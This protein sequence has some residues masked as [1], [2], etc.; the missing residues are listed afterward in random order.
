[1]NTIYSENHWP[2]FH[3]GSTIKNYVA[4]WWGLAKCQQHYISSCDKI[5]NER[6]VPKAF[7][8]SLWMSP[9]FY[10]VK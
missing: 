5:V 8:L 1:M 2:K 6:G 9:K 3:Y 4:R 7:Q 10:V